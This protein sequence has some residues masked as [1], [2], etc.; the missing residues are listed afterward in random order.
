MRYSLF[1]LFF[2][3]ASVLVMA[4]STNVGTFL[5][6]A[7]R[8]AD[9]Y[10]DQFAY[11]NAQ[12]LYLRVLDKNPYDLYARQKVGECYK[13]LMEYEKAAAWY[14]EMIVEYDA[15][16]TTYLPYAEV[17]TTLGR[18]EEAI[19]YYQKYLE[20]QPESIRAKSRLAFLE[21]IDFYLRDSVLYEI[22]DAGINTPQS[23][24]GAGFYFNNQLI[25][26]SNRDAD[27]LV[28][29]KS[30]DQIT[31]EESLFNFFIADA[32]TNKNYANAR[33]M[34]TFNA[35]SRFHDGPFS[36]YN[37]G[38]KVAFTRTSMAGKKPDRDIDGRAN[39]KIFFADIE[40]GILTNME[41]FPHNLDGYSNG[42]PSVTPDGTAMYYASTS[43]FGLGKSDIYVSYKLSNGRWTEP[44]N[45][46]PEV[47]TD[48][49]E[50]YPHFLNDSTLLFA[51]TGH[52]GF[53]GLDIFMSMKRNGKFT[54]PFNLGYPLNSSY[55]DFSLVFDAS[56]RY[57]AFSSNRPKGKGQDDIY[58]IEAGYYSLAGTVIQEVTGQILPRAKVDVFDSL[59]APVATTLSDGDG[60]F[61]VD[62]PF[63]G[64][65]RILASKDGYYQ[66]DSLRYST[67]RLPIGMDSIRLPLRE[68]NLFSSGIV[69]SH[70]LHE[71]IPDA[72]VIFKNLTEWR[73]DTVFT[74]PQGRYRQR[75]IPN[76]RYNVASYKQGFLKDDFNL[77][78]R[79][80]VKG[81]LKNDF[82]L[83]MEYH[84][85]RILQF[86][87]DKALIKAEALAD[88]EESVR[89]LK[90]MPEATVIVSAFAD[91]TGTKE[92]NKSL[93]VRRLKAVVDY[94]TKNGI[95]SR[96]IEGHAFGEDLLLNHCSDGVECDEDDHAINRRAEVKIQLPEHRNF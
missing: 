25:F 14:Q 63:D 76:R 77:N 79:N 5:F 89:I 80:L 54:K 1:T 60:N 41:E 87:F 13:R 70:E 21:N 69:Y 16:Y 19:T 88:L 3:L 91:A 12:T 78:T 65:Y 53:G 52:G 94:L 8:K 83:E 49:E 75:L 66:H 10:F 90:E 84:D 72:F 48:G 4:Q 56:G 46:G 24:F 26:V 85:K 33:L 95:S 71:S 42:H 81:E 55:D 29:H 61:F 92:Y 37:Y 35:Q 58:I 73:A 50:L 34:Q 38:T 30:M 18:I 68:H 9:H 6:D 36:L 2:C 39:L 47:N 28:K 51:S 22:R 40:N 43:P 62:L 96:R 67:Y 27:F 44:E 20:S 64:N 59:G 45:L 57:G 15:G 32:G 82:V 11:R 17:L 7:V 93:S 31:E 74:D 23:E 86:D